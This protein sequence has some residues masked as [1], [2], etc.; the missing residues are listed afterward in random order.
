MS[1][2][3]LLMAAAMKAKRSWE[4][5]PPEQRQRMLQGAKTTVQT[6]GP[7]VARK[8]ADTARAHGP[9]IARAAADTAQK[10]AETAR[11]QGPVIARRIAEA[12]EKARKSS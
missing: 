2:V 10:A 4:R 6:K 1:R 3:K 12:I 9:T 8:A 11:T 7:I 5:I